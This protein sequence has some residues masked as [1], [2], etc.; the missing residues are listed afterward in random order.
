MTSV[1][2]SSVFDALS[3][4]ASQKTLSIS[5]SPLG[6]KIGTFDLFLYISSKLFTEFHLENRIV[7]IS[8]KSFVDIIPLFKDTIEIGFTE[9]HMIISDE[10]ALVKIPFLLFQG[11]DFLDQWDPSQIIL[12]TIIQPASLLNSIFLVP[13]SDGIV[14]F[15]IGTSLQFQIISILGA[16][17]TSSLSN[18]EK[19]RFQYPKNSLTLRYLYKKFIQL[20][21]IL[22]KASKITLKMNED[23]VLQWQ[24]LI[25]VEEQNIYAEYFIEPLVLEE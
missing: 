15:Q 25:P 23:G 14:E 16:K 3:M 4:F 5:V 7:Q 11:R 17:I 20:K 22:K 2:T 21:G 24:M 10:N 19:F 18:L 6:L 8:S 1:I 9:S 13:I 12:N